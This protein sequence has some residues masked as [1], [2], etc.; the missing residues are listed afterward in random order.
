MHFSHNFCC[1]FHLMGAPRSA[2]HKCTCMHS[3]GAVVR[4]DRTES[5]RI[6]YQFFLGDVV[7]LTNKQG[8]RN[9]WWKC[10]KYDQTMC[11][12]YR[13]RCH[14]CGALVALANVG[15]LLQLRFAIVFIDTQSMPVAFRKS[16]YIFH[17]HDPNERIEIK[18]LFNVQ[19]ECILQASAFLRLMGGF[20]LHF[21]QRAIV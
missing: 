10:I 1:L 21:R 18:W 16:E 2:R 4:S 15:R 12:E 8:N 14:G 11:G 20:H 3:H 17:S 5:M 6:G 19:C 13:F 9:R 7:G